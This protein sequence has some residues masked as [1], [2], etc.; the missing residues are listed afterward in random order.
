MHY[1]KIFDYT[2]NVRVSNSEDI[3][4]IHNNCN[5]CQYH[6]QFNEKQ[7]TFPTVTIIGLVLLFKERKKK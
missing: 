5:D 1:K 2:Q 4:V 7:T 3:P 6:K